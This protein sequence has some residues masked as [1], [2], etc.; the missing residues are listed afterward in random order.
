MRYYEVY[1]SSPRYHGD[2]ALTYAS[3][4][5]LQPG[6]VVTVPLQ[7]QTVLG[8]VQRATRK[9][10]FATKPISQVVTDRPLTA[11]LLQLIDWFKNYYPAPFGTI[12]QTFLPRAITPLKRAPK[13]PEAVAATKKPSAHPELPKLPPLTTEQ[14]EALDTIGSSPAH[15]FLV[16]GETGTG[17]TRLYVELAR[18]C[19]EK[20]QSVIILTPEIGLTPQLVE[21][22]TAVFP[23]QVITVHSTQTPAQRRRQWQTILTSDGPLV[24]IGPRSA[25]FSPLAT[26]GLIV[27]DEAHDSAYKQEQAP[28]YL[29]SRVA[30][31][32]ASLHGAQLVLGSATPNV[33]D[34]YTFA[35]KKLPIIRMLASAQTAEP[36]TC[37]VVDQRDRQQ[38]SRSPWLSDPL[39]SAVGDVLQRQEQAL[40]FLNR[41]GTA[42]LVVCTNCGWEARCPRCDLPL[43]FHADLHVL[44]CHTCGTTA[45]V[46]S[47]CP[48]CGHADILFRSIGTK[49]LVSELGKLFPEARI[50]RFDSDTA[51]AERLEQ[52]YAA[53]KDGSVDLL[54]GTQ[55]VG[56]GLDL[57][58]L[59]LVGVVQADTSLS[60]PD[61]TAEERSFQLLR[62]VI[63]RVGRG[64]RAGRVIIQSFQPGNSTLQFAI[65]RDYENF[66]QQQL[67][68]RERYHFPPFYFTLQLKLA[69][70]SQATAERKAKALATDLAARHLPIE[71]V[72]P[73]PAFIEKSADRYHWHLIVK[74]KRRAVLTD[75]VHNLPAGWTYDLDPIDLL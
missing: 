11:Q 63:G 60:F 3:E 24:V 55:T 31:Q 43:T 29:T 6:Q 70:A 25:L 12:L 10:A 30:A 69:Q 62:Q 50:K 21:V 41:R 57:P 20:K 18:R 27:I 14:K 26:I 13:T 51:T 40:L 46:P 47:A 75:L 59:S 73:S 15:S 9:P 4:Q 7:R 67:A 58:R 19:L 61:Y 5:E 71:I 68:E 17:K 65:N 2:S 54:V 33:G 8:I 53:I 52:H 32:L 38:F 44:R 64:H 49:L 1:V 36:V 42:R 22:F 23:G 74:A 66:Y 45:D 35:A 39:L 37:E 34:Y 72:G 56:K 28:Y 48:T 16:H